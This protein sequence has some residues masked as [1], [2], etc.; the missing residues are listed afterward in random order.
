[1]I[2]VPDERIH[3]GVPLT[4]VAR[5]GEAEIDGFNGKVGVVE[6]QGN[7][8]YVDHDASDI[9]VEQ[10]KYQVTLAIHTAEDHCRPVHRALE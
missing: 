2:P 6:T 3:G 10:R 4:H 8:L 7:I 5:E 9:I 1:M